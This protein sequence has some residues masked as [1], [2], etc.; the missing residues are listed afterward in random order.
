M[1][2]NSNS[3]ALVARHTRDD[4][5]V[6]HARAD[7]FFAGVLRAFRD[8]RHPFSR[9]TS[10]FQAPFEPG[11]FPADPLLRMNYYLALCLW[12]KGQ[13]ESPV[14][15]YRLSR[16]AVD[17]PEIFTPRHWLVDGDARETRVADA[18]AELKRR[19][20]GVGVEKYHRHHLP[21]NYRKVATHWDGDPRN[22]F[23]FPA[24]TWKFS[25][26]ESR[27]R[28]LGNLDDEGD[29]NGFFGFQIKMTALLAHFGV[30]V[31]AVDPV[32]MPYPLPVDIHV[33]RVLLNQG[34]L[35]VTRAD[36]L[37]PGVHG[38][39]LGYSRVVRA[40]V[41]AS[42]VFLEKTGENAFDLAEAVWNFGL[43]MCAPRPSL[44]RVVDAEGRPTKSDGRRTILSCE[45]PLDTEH[46]R[47]RHRATCLSCPFL[48]TC[49]QRLSVGSKPYFL[50]G[51]LSARPS[52]FPAHWPKRRG[53]GELV[54]VG[55]TRTVG[56]MGTWWER[57]GRPYRP[58]PPREDKPPTTHVQG[59]MLA[60][61]GFDE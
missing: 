8:R 32:A 25:S 39:D 49:E 54:D 51:R 44:W 7:E 40:G 14:A 34:V 13:I 12:M 27:V 28:N 3:A 52:A 57:A 48:S 19:G 47:K 30:V 2:K 31:G 55:P 18:V 53:E 45:T 42:L 11:D 38:W 46:Q 24:G 33:A 21:F 26:F 59:S 37:D 61:L 4:V 58:P 16:L 23:R 29:P 50:L 6:D 60:A 35:R 5:A 22:L 56:K 36:G 15:H 41:E 17:R 43:E 20:L 10:I 1:K 9:Y